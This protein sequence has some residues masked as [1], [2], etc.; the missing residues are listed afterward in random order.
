MKKVSHQILR[1]LFRSLFTASRLTSVFA[2]A[3]VMVFSPFAPL[4]QTARADDS[5]GDSSTASSTPVL[6]AP[7]SV[8]TTTLPTPPVVMTGDATN[9]ATTSA[10]IAYAITDTGSSPDITSYGLKYASDA[11]YQNGHTYTQTV[12]LTNANGN[13]GSG[14]SN[15]NSLTCGTT[16]H[17]Q[18][19]ATNADAQTGTGT[20]ATFTTSD[21]AVIN[22][23]APPLGTSTPPTISGRGGSGGA[24][25]TSGSVASSSS[26]EEDATT[27]PTLPDINAKPAVPAGPTQDPGSVSGI[28]QSSATIS[29]NLTGTGVGDPAPTFADVTV[30]YATDGRY[31]D[32]STYNFH[33]DQ[34]VPSGDTGDVLLTNLMCGTKYHYVITVTNSLTQSNT[35]ADDTFTTTAC[36]NTYVEP[37]TNNLRAYWKFDESTAGAT[38]V[39]SSANANNGTRNG[40]LDLPAASTDVPDPVVFSDSHSIAPTTNSEIDVPDASS[41]NF[42]GSFTI[43]FWLKPTT[44]ADGAVHGIVS[45]MGSGG[46][47]PG[48]SIQDDPN[49]TSQISLVANGTSG[50]TNTG[51]NASVDVNQWQH[52]AVV[53]NATDETLSWYKNG[54]LTGK[55]NGVTLGDLTNSNTLE[56]LHTEQEGG[57]YYQGGLDDLRM[58]GY[59]LTDAQIAQLGSGAEVKAFNGGD[60]S[61]GSPYQITTCDDLAAVNDKPAADYILENDL[62]CTAYGTQVMIGAPDNVFTGDFNGNNHKIILGISTIV[63]NLGLFAYLGG[64]VHDLWV[65]GTVSGDSNVGGVAGVAESGGDIERVKSTVAVTGSGHYIGGIVG[66]LNTATIINSYA[67]GAVYGGPINNTHSANTLGGLVGRTQGMSEIESSYAASDVTGRYSAGGLV[68]QAIDGGVIND[69]FAVGTVS[70]SVHAGELIGIVQGG[71]GEPSL[72]NDLFA[73]DANSYCAADVG[74][75]MLGCTG[76]ADAQF[77]DTDG[78]APF[79]TNWDFTSVWGTTSTYPQLQGVDG[80]SGGGNTLIVTTLADN[81]NGTCTLMSCTFRDAIANAGEH[82]TITFADNV[83]GTLT[84]SGSSE[85]ITYNNITIEGPGANL[86]TVDFNNDSSNWIGFEGQ[87]TSTISGLT[88]T[89]APDAVAYVDTGIGGGLNVSNSVFTNNTVYSSIFVDRGFLSV[90]SST[91]TNNTVEYAG[92]GAIF[93]DSNQ[94]ITV[95]SST[96]TGNNYAGSND[97][98]YYSAGGGAIE[99]IGLGNVTVASSTFTGNSAIDGGALLINSGNFLSITNS[100]F[101]SNIGTQWIGAVDAE[102]NSLYIDNS[103]FENNATEGYGYGTLLNTASDSIIS[104]STFDNNTLTDNHNNSGGGAIYNVGNAV[105]LINDTFTGNTVNGSDVQGGGAVYNAGILGIINSTFSDDV[106]ADGSIGTEIYNAPSDST[107]IQNTIVQGNTEDNC[108]GD[109]TTISIGYNIDSGNS[110]NLNNDGDQINTDPL[111]SEA[112]LAN[113][114]GLVETIA[115]QPSSSAIDAGTESMYVPSFDARGVS[116]PQ[117]FDIDI[118]AYEY[119]GN[120]PV[121]SI[122]NPIASSTVTQWNPITAWGDS[123]PGQCYYQYDGT[124][125]EGWIPVETCNTSGSISAPTPGLHTLYIEGIDDGGATVASTTFNYIVDSTGGRTSYVWTALDMPYNGSFNRVYVSRDGSTIAVTTYGDYIYIS[126]DGGSTWT[127]ATDAG[128]AYWN[129]LAMSADGKHIIAGAANYWLYRSDDGGATWN[130]ISAR[131]GYFMS[132]AMSDDGTYITAVDNN[133]VLWISSDSGNSWT[134]ND[135]FIGHEI[136]DVAMS[137]DG[138]YQILGIN[139]FW[140]GGGFLY[141]SSDYGNTWVQQG[142]S[143]KVFTQVAISSDGAHETA[144]T[145][146]GYMYHSNDFGANWPGL[147]EGAYGGGTALTAQGQTLFESTAGNTFRSTDGGNTI[148]TEGTLAR[149]SSMS[150]SANGGVVVA[151]SGGVFIGTPTISGSGSSG[152]PY[153]I[154]SCSDLENING[155]LNATYSLQN[156]LD[157]S[158]DGNN[159]MIGAD[160]TPFTGTFNGNGHKITIALTDAGDE[161]GLFRKTSGAHISNLWVAGTINA[162]DFHQRTGG[163]IGYAINTTVLTSIASTVHI[164]TADANSY[165]IGGIVG[166]LDNSL[167]QDSYFKGTVFGNEWVGGLVGYLQTSTIARSYNAGTVTSDSWHH[168]VGE[169]AGHVSADSNVVNS[170]AVGAVTEPNGFFVA[171]LVGGMNSNIQN[172]FW[173]ITSTGITDCADTSSGSTEGQCQGVNGDGSQSNYF[174]GNHTNAPFTTDWDFTSVWDTVDGGYP[175]LRGVANDETP[176][177]VGNVSYRYVKWEITKRKGT[178]SCDQACIQASEFQ[179]LEDGDVVAWPDGTTAA[180]PG[181]SNTADATEGALKAIDGDA[182]T[183]WL[184]SNFNTNSSSLTG[185]SQL[186][187]DTGSGHSVSFNAY[188][189]YTGNDDTQRD[190]VSWNVYG[191]ND[192]STWTL[193]D[194][195]SDES[196]TDTRY[197]NTYPY[198][199]FTPAFNGGEGTVI[200]PFQINTCA[201]FENI[202]QNLNR[203]FLL[204]TNLDCSGDGNNVM[205]GTSDTP[206]TGHF[207]GGGHTIHVAISS[208]DTYIG[209]FRYIS[210]AVIKNLNITGDVEGSHELGALVGEELNSQIDHVSSAASVGSNGLGNDNGGLIGYASGGIISNTF[211]TG[212]VDGS[213][214]VGGLIGQVDGSH[215]SN[216][217]ASGSVTGESNVGGLVGGGTTSD[218][219]FRNVFATGL[220]TNSGGNTGGLSGDVSNQD[221]YVNSSYSIGDTGVSVCDGAGTVTGCVGEFSAGQDEWFYS[222]THAPLSSWDFNGYVWQQNDGGFPTFADPFVATPLIITGGE[223]DV[224]SAPTER[225]ATFTGTISTT[226]TSDIYDRGFQYGIDTSYGSTTE[227]SIDGAFGTGDFSLQAEGLMCN[228]T[229]HYRA[230]T[231]DNIGTAY[232]DDATFTTGPCENITI[233]SPVDG[234]T[235]THGEWNPNIGWSDQF[236]TCEYAYNDDP[237]TELSSCE[238]SVPSPETEGEYTLHLRGTDSQEVQITAS[239]TFNYQPQTTFDGLGSGTSEDPYEITSCLELQEMDVHDNANYELMN[240]IDCSDTENWNDGSGFGVISF[241]GVLDGKSHTIQN[242]YMNWPN[243][244]GVGLFSYFGGA[245]FNVNMTGAD[246]SGGSNTG[247]FVG[248]SYGGLLIGVSSDGDV[249]NENPQEF[250]AAGGLVGAGSGTSILKSS[251]TG[252][253]YS[254]GMSESGGLIGAMGYGSSI[255]NS[256]ASSTVEAFGTGGLVGFIFNDYGG[257]SISHS[258]AAGTQ[259]GFILDGGLI[260][261]AVEFGNPSDATTTITSSFSVDRLV[262]FGEGSNAGGIIGYLDTTNPPVLTSVYYDQ[263]AGAGSDCMGENSTTAD[264]TSSGYDD[265]TPINTDGTDD[266]HYVSTSSPDVAPLGD[267]DFDTVWQEVDGELPQLQPQSDVNIATAPTNLAVSSIGDLSIPLTWTAPSDTSGLSIQYYQYF[268]EPNGASLN[269]GDAGTIHGTTDDATT[270]A[271]ISD[272]LLTYNSSF[273]VRVRAHTAYGYGAWSDPYTMTFGDPT[274]HH[275]T[276]CEDLQAVGEYGAYSYADT[277]LLDNDIDCSGIE[278][279]QPIGDNWYGHFRGIFNG[280]GHTINNL[281]MNYPENNNIGLFTQTRGAT[282]ENVNFGA[283]DGG[284]GSVTGQN[285][286]G[287]ATGYAQDTT[288]SNITSTL[289]VAGND[290]VGGIVGRLY[291]YSNASISSSTVTADITAN[292]EVGGLA[293]YV[294]EYD[295]YGEDTYL[296]ITNDVFNGNV[297]SNN[298][299]YTG[300]IAGAVD[301]EPS[302]GSNTS[303]TVIISDDHAGGTVAGGVYIGGLFGY[304]YGGTSGNSSLDISQTRLYSTVAVSSNQNYVGGLI[305]YAEVYNDGSDDSVTDNLSESYNTGIVTATAGAYIGGLVGYVGID[306]SDSEISGGVTDSYSTADVIANASENPTAEVGGLV[307]ESYYAPIERSYASGS[308]IGTQ[309]VGGLVGYN[310]GGNVSDSFSTTAVSG[311]GDYS[312]LGGFVGYDIGDG[313]ITNNYYDADQSLMGTENCIDGDTADGCTAISGDAYHFKHT[314]SVDPFTSGNWDFNTVWDSVAGLYPQL[315]NVYQVQD[316]GT[317]PVVTT[318]PQTQNTSRGGHGSGGGSGTI[319]ALSGLLAQLASLQAQLAALQKA[320]SVTANAAVGTN[321]TPASL[322]LTMGSQGASVKSLQLFLIAQATGP[323][324]QALAKM[325]ATGYFSTYTRDALIEYQKAKGIKPAT[326]YFGPLTRAQM[327]TA[328]VAGLW[329]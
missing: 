24:G 13:P 323:A 29:Y 95:A 2:V 194:S 102:A 123:N 132:V 285:E 310:Y 269:P 203:A 216:S 3:A 45:K 28:G 9:V 295:Y 99:Y 98:G 173:D 275:I 114:G 291:D 119:A 306:P 183:K 97:G 60:G 104:N 292:Q 245:I 242:L 20:D 297:S 148:S 208:G 281:T 131:E 224:S 48:F 231:T 101:D 153:V 140:I 21:C 256:F 308:V 105:L 196:I 84:L 257:A 68:G 318:P 200:D 158:G 210:G 160:G 184:D 66:T 23:P 313:S 107:Y 163:L 138:Q 262:P 322:D 303:N 235:I 157:C 187:I 143:A 55:Y 195:R 247:S 232:G 57:G 207:N 287:V 314:S 254:S 180:N 321:A 233:D 252:T 230:F 166:Q 302:S 266:S 71:S 279:F 113:N 122:T 15:I 115:L 280:Q 290:Q 228:T 325:T 69:S 67:T 329:W 198:T 328:D 319:H 188:K 174:K 215:V 177:G 182:T 326:G 154:T 130:Q 156:D 41:L 126:H 152:D 205:I 251:F 316:P 110:C 64:A 73:N 59:V 112:G 87:G 4:L 6:S 229:Y 124:D 241:G 81:G 197:T 38:A 56:I 12:Q 223:T 17:Y 133:G 214:N 137:G 50:G 108:A 168:P 80:A 111:L 293:G 276:S 49:A 161:V 22:T 128:Q 246:I 25:G 324:A 129:G 277:I 34:G 171:D 118:G 16:Y 217:Y 267:F 273:D 170:F 53:Y 44:W 78:V 139:D 120:G 40:E 75:G 202:N 239:T 85:L 103:T 226:G 296:A 304:V 10:T 186:V 127:T 298:G 191:S 159:A 268:V 219:S 65:D 72:S 240:N 300:G 265:C 244:N 5:A 289:N 212:N 43:A 176:P 301:A 263:T 149:S 283:T 271:L 46:S 178:G 42:N 86:L 221:T 14:T 51:L 172:N 311:V 27:T 145:S 169:I 147:F 272:L 327:K 76:Q 218:H 32:A 26:N 317:D 62:D 61:S 121:I 77:R 259:S 151:L 270:T 31:G 39:D 83:R 150:I 1:L 94:D 8:A 146:D 222:A 30:S 274:V 211:A 52:L 89:D 282:I 164:L 162:M 305:G 320:S 37:L 141:M 155:A 54:T 253:A 220:L 193:I 248:Q 249:S 255:D 294:Y 35:T 258:Y 90:A 237:Y 284:S 199:S 250:G 79:T 93:S 70:A 18:A 261:A 136:D 238:A 264:G 11:E 92:G 190:P 82:D 117:G 260:G 179:L 234:T 286:V 236:V 109:G 165:T 7:P 47:D 299:Y 88:L 307:G 33:A 278:N 243:E 91:F 96:F 142:I 106:A 63:S 116:R 227:D 189:W 36:T 209:L 100:T 312:D 167:L 309:Y 125:P 192:G 225:T 206:F 201:E 181:G 19:F 135:T 213:V 185:D 74:G 204:T 175:S 144:I 288:F 315:R 58:Y 134:E